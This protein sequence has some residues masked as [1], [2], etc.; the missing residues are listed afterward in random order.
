MERQSSAQVIPNPDMGLSARAQTGTDTEERAPRRRF[1]RNL[2]FAALGAGAVAPVVGSASARAA[3]TTPAYTDASNVFTADQRVD[4]RVGI[5]V[6]P[7][8]PL[9][10]TRADSGSAL[11]VD[12]HTMALELRHDTD[13]QGE[14][15]DL[16]NLFHKS[17]GDAI[18]IAHQGG[19]PPGYSGPVGGNAGLNVLVPY[20][21]DSATTGRDGSV[22]NDRTGMKGLHIETQAVV[23]GSNAIDIQHFSNAYAMN[24]V[25]QPPAQGQPVGRG[26]AAYVD[27]YSQSATVRVDKWTAPVGE[28]VLEINGRAQGA[29]NALFVR[30]ANAYAHFRLRSDGL[31]RLVSSGAIGLEATSDGKLA[32]GAGIQLGTQYQGWMNVAGVARN[33][34]LVN[35]DPT[36]GA[37]TSI[38]F[39]DS[40][41]QYAFIKAS[42]DNRTAGARA[43]SML[44]QVRAGD[45]VS[46]RLRLDG[47]GLGFFGAASAGR[48]VVAGSRG[49]AKGLAALLNALSGMGLITD[50]S[51]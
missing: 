8:T 47:G 50:S 27:D 40:G 30:D 42:Y 37:G 33:I 6:A 32:V 43:S 3:G 13:W 20:T 18:F 38:E 31:T 26:G 16:A 11:R 34:A 14:V 22:V 10:V 39:D 19:K 46:D 24:V 36:P 29:M 21:L 9:H 51:S 2:S 28:A 25:V 45:A 48:P 44:F 7:A 12:A 15:H 1:L 23:D 41:Y 5:G 4:A 49:N 17:T 35:T